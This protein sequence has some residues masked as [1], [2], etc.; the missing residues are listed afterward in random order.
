MDQWQVLPPFENDSPFLQISVFPGK[1]VYTWCYT[2]YTFTGKDNSS[3]KMIL[4]NSK[5]SWHWW[6]AVAHKMDLKEIWS[7]DFIVDLD[8]LH[9][10]DP[11]LYW[12]LK[13]H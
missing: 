2:N 6:V 9:F 11:F 5:Q 8:T 12:E 13:I 3:E 10:F 1:F 7:S 4:S